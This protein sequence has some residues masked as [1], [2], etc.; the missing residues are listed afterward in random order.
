MD[1]IRIRKI[2][3]A[4]RKNFNKSPK[5]Y[6]TFENKYKLF[7]FLALELAKVSGIKKNNTIL[8]IG[9]G[10]GAS[11]F[12]LGKI[13][14]NK[15]IGIDFSEEMI[16]NAINLKNEN[17]IENV[18]FLCADADSL[19]DYFDYAFDFVLYNAS[20]FLIPNTEISLGETYKILKKGGKV[21]L[22][23]LKGAEYNNE[24]IF[25][26]VSTKFQELC[27]TFHK[28]IMDIDSIEDFLRNIGFKDIRKGITRKKMK[29][30]ELKDFYS[31]PAQSAS[32]WP[33]LKYEERIIKINQLFDFLEC[34]RIDEVEQVWLWF[35][36][37]K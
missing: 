13:I 10:T 2:K 21:C 7:E 27:P 4:V 17:Q 12:L 18:E 6:I 8:D 35:V 19:S 34:E 36:G 30:L 28:P 11:T 3:T 29:I 20:I 15:V 23:L 16:E 33:K 37:R 9:C 22:N 5:Q 25:N 24:D 14:N 32:L 26:L 31:I 1:E